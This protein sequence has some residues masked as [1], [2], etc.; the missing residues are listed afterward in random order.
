[1]PRLINNYP[2]IQLFCFQLPPQQFGLA[3]SFFAHGEKL[4]SFEQRLNFLKKCKSCKIFPAFIENNLQ[5]N[6][7]A[8]FPHTT[9]P[10]VTQ[11]IFSIKLQAL[12][13]AIADHYGRIRL[14]KISIIETRQK[15]HFY[16]FY[17]SR[18]AFDRIQS[19]FE[20]NNECVKCPPVL[21]DS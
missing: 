21:L 17:S 18:P 2:I 11:M 19:L 16:L 9:P 14:E 7:T 4:K 8:L 15:L 12:N 1:M 10:K 5:F 13:I 20:Q 6:A 3:K